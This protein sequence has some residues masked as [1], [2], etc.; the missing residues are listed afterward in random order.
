M[1]K[2]LNSAKGFTIIEMI[3]AVVILAM[4]VIV[5]GDLYLKGTLSSKTEMSRSKLQIETKNVVEGMN[6]NIKL[7][8]KIDST[9]NNGTYNASATTLILDLPAIDGT[10]T[11]L[12]SGNQ[13][14]HDYI[15]Y[16]LDGSNLHKMVFSPDSRSRLYSEN[17]SDQTLLSNVKTLAF[18]YDTA[19]PASVTVTIDITTQDTSQK[20]VQE[21]SVNTEAKRRN[22]D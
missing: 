7:A 14:I 3:F 18:T 22:N 2:I 21:I 4:M 13:K 20:I 10:S 15:I 1:K 11:F 9:Y 17:G 19:P 6:A 16:Y 12:Y 8:S 5:I